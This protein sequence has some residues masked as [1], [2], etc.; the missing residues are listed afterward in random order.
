VCGINARNKDK[1][2]GG[3]GGRDRVVEERKVVGSFYYLSTT[4]NKNR[5]ELVIDL[6]TA[7]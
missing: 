7:R 6:E 2:E 1:N 4:H 5:N 3:K